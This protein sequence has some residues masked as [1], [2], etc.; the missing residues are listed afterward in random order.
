MVY[1]IKAGKK[2]IQIADTTGYCQAIGV[3]VQSL[4]GSGSVYVSTE[5]ALLDQDKDT[6][7]G[8]PK[9][10]I[11]LQQLA[12][13]TNIPSTETWAPFRSILFAR[14]VGAADSDISVEFFPLE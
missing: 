1:T 8:H 11:L 2:S 3:K 7:T 5:Q 12:T 10:G 4:D 6:T 14:N 13:P 9:G